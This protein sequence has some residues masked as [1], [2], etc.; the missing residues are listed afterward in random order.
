MTDND[1][2]PYLMGIL[3][4]LIA[5]TIIVATLWAIGVLQFKARE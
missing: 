4:A 2:D 3:H 1:G 5:V